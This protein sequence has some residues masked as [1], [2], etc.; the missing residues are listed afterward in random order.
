M[1]QGPTTQRSIILV[2][3]RALH[4]D[5]TEGE[6]KRNEKALNYVII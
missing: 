4:I 2:E 6:G 3:E 5:N 1:T